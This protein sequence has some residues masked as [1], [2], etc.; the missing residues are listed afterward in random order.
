MRNY[1]KRLMRLAEQLKTDKPDRQPMI[2]RFTHDLHKIYGDK[3]QPPTTIPE[4]EFDQVLG[5]AITK[6]YGGK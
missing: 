4:V 1:E 6:V 2:D 3:D 5:K